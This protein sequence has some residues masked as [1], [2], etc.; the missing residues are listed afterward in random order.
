[1]RSLTQAHARAG[2]Q[3]VA[4]PVF[5]RP[6]MAAAAKLFIVAAGP[7]DAIRSCQ[8]LFG[9]MGQRT[10]PV[11]T[12]TAAASLVK[13][14]GNFMVAAAIEALGEALA[15][16]A[17][18]GVDPGSF[19]DVLTSTLFPAPAYRAYGAL[20]AE[21]KFEPAGVAAPLGHKDVRLL[22]AASESLHVPMPIASLL[23]DRLLRLIAQ[24]GEKLDWSAIGQLAAQDAGLR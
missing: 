6:E 20:I 1:M 10:L 22:L 24:G 19:V 2:Q 21:R 11:G 18:A 7:A 3:L 12:E 9:S 8:L 17:K 23:N 4:A 5:G 16:V 13:L 15:L 14:A